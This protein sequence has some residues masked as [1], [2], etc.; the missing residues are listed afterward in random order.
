MFSKILL[1]IDLASEHSWKKPL[2]L[3]VEIARHGGAE[4]HVMAV[5]PDLDRK[6]VV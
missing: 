4:I 1:P 6:S 3:A 2:R 5:L